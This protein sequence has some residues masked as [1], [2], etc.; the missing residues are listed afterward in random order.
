[1]AEGFLEVQQTIREPSK[2]LKEAKSVG[3][4]EKRNTTPLR[5]KVEAKVPKKSSFELMEQ[6]DDSEE[7][8][9]L[10]GDQ[11]YNSGLDQGDQSERLRRF[12]SCEEEDTIDINPLGSSSFIPTEGQQKT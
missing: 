10:E 8:E 11:L 12:D 9:S 3:K 4:G 1:M 7:G 2:G 5:P 6:A